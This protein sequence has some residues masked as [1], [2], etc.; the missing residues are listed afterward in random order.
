MDIQ[1]KLTGFA[2]MG[3]TWIMWLLVALSVGGVAVALERA[4]YLIFTRENVRK[5]KQQI[6]ALLR[7][8]D[9]DEARARLARSRSHVAGIIA[10]ALEGHGDGTAAA[11]ERMNGATQLAKLRMEKRLAFLGTLGSN[12]PFIGL[13]GTV[14]G[15]IRAFHQLNDAAGKVTSG[16]MAEVGEA[17][18]ATAIGI[19]VA[20]PAIAFY[21]AFQR[22]I[23]ARLARAQ[24]FG[25]EVLALLKAEHAPR[26]PARRLAAE[27]HAQ[28][29]RRQPSPGGGVVMAAQAANDDEMI[30]GINVTPLV[31][32]TLVLLVI[33]MVTASYVTS[34]AI[35]VELPKGATGEATPT[36]LTISIDKDGKTFLDAEAISDARCR[37]RSRRCTTRDPETRAIIAADG[38]TTHSNVIH[39]IDL[40]RRENVTK[41]AINVDPE[42]V[43]RR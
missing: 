22:I 2:M 27:S 24:A 40:L 28:R 43:A 7:K 25:N 3:A 31:D 16:L 21:N 39:V 12:A 36:T 41:F 19:L 33:L 30:T 15:I 20:L 18:V 8:G 35:P 34:R 13:L 4:I 9:L 23:R 14:I 11:E 32:I 17:L 42:E 26:A 38:R 37:R 5:L 1:Q 10:A 6:L 29:R